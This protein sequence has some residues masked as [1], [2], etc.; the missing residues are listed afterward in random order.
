MQQ[1][2]ELPRLVSLVL[3]VEHRLQAI[4]GECHA[5]NKREVMRPCL[6]VLLRDL[7]RGEAEVELDAVVTA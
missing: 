1:H 3:H 7:R 5:V 4:A 2:L 6:F